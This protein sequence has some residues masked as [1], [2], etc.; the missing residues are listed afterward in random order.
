[1]YVVPKAHE[2]TN[3]ATHAQRLIRKAGVAKWPKIFHNLRASRET[4]LM[5]EHP[6]HVVLTWIGH[7]AAVAQSHYLQVTEA[8]FEKASGQ[9][10]QKAAQSA[11]VRRRQVASSETLTSEKP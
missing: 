1:M 9:V 6:A 8:D 11:S 4:E 7:T 2:T 10:A 3:V 5:R